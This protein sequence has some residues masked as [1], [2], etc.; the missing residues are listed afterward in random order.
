MVSLSASR[1]VVPLL[2]LVALGCAH[3]PRQGPV[4]PP[5]QV[6]AEPQPARPAHER[7]ARPIAEGYASWYGGSLRGHLT[8]N[9]ERFNPSALTAAHRTL[10]F[11]TC[12][13]VENVENG[14]S[15][16]VRVNDR[17]PYVSGRILDVSE[18][19]ARRLDMLHDGVGRVRLFRCGS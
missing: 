18:G 19:A 8:A 2:L 14:R 9:G 5:P 10:P 3:A 16:N 7:Q 1:R 11:G 12:L 17:G 4:E 15:V 13:H 6:S